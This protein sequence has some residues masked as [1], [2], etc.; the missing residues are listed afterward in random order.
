MSVGAFLAAAER[1]VAL[2]KPD[3]DLASGVGWTINHI[4]S[5]LL[6]KQKI[7]PSDVMQLEEDGV[8]TYKRV[9]SVDLI[10]LVEN[11]HE[12]LEL[13]DMVVKNVE[14]ILSMAKDTTTVA[15]VC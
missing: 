13:V 15:N 5:K 11:Q 14:K 1:L 8:L 6:D 7:G 2:Y 9:F 10:C 3:A 12:Q 4:V